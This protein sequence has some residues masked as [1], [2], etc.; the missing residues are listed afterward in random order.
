MR[1]K[2]TYRVRSKTYI[3]IDSGSTSDRSA[4]SIQNTRASTAHG[5]RPIPFSGRDMGTP[6]CVRMREVWGSRLAY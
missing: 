2:L 5:R 3:D 1:R 6:S 4:K